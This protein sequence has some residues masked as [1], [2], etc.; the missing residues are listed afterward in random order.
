MRSM[1][2]GRRR[3]QERLGS[4]KRREKLQGGEKGGR[5]IVRCHKKEK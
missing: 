2:W 3:N 5:D 4:K 1:D